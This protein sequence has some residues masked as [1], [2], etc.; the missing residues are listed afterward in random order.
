L[1]GKEKLNKKNSGRPKGMSQ[2]GRDD[3]ASAQ[4]NHVFAHTE[5]VGGFRG[6]GAQSQRKRKKGL[7]TPTARKESRR[8][9]SHRLKLGGEVQLSKNSKEKKYLGPRERGGGGLRANKKTG[10]ARRFKEGPVGGDD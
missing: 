2:E 4:R 3:A 8:I 7:N 10:P 6:G 1:L 9:W 5:E